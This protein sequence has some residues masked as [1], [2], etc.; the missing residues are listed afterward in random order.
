MEKSQRASSSV[1]DKEQQL[2]M[3]KRERVE[4]DCVAWDAR[5]KQINIKLFS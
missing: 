5:W 2:T 3:L 1:K 4:D